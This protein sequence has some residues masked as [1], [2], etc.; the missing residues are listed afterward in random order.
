MPGQEALSINYGTVETAVTF[1]SP[2]CNKT[3]VT[4]ILGK[5][6]HHLAAMYSLLFISIAAY[7]IISINS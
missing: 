6:I 4:R 2:D 7:H 1:S 3:T 5:N